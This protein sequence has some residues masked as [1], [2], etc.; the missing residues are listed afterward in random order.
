MKGTIDLKTTADFLDIDCQTLRII[1]Q[2]GGVSWAS[3]VKGRGN[4]FIYLIYEKP[5]REATGYNPQK[6][7]ATGEFCEILLDTIRQLQ[8]LQTSASDDLFVFHDCQK[9]IDYLDSEVDHKRR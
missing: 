8:D 6:E 1:I 9:I 4:D 2:N 5:F 3:A 7:G